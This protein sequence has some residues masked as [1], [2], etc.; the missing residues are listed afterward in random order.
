MSRIQSAIGRLRK[1]GEAVPLMASLY[2][3]SNP[4]IGAGACDGELDELSGRFREGIP[5]DYREFLG[6]CRAISAMDVFS[7]YAFYSPLSLVSHDQSVPRRI[8]VVGERGLVEVSV[9]AVAGDGGGNQFLLGMSGELRGRVWK[10]SHE[11]PVRFDGVA[12]AG[13]N[14]VASNFTEFLE[15]VADDWEHFVSATKGW[16][17]LSG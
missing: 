6:S 14:A 4:I 15:R 7:G 9:L 11:D 5:S 10:W 12:N 8:H 3:L 16:K 1:S 17:S 13:L 2:P